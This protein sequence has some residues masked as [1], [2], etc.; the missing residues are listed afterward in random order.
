MGAPPA[1][2][3]STSVPRSGTTTGRRPAPSVS[4]T[5]TDAGQVGAERD[6]GAVAGRQRAGG[7]VEPGGAT[8]HDR[9]RPGRTR[10]GA[11]RAVRRHRPGAQ[12]AHLAGVGPVHPHRA[13]RGADRGAHRAADL[14]RRARLAQPLDRPCLRTDQVR[15]TDD[16]DPDRD[17]VARGA[18]R[19][20]DGE[21]GAGDGRHGVAGHDEPLPA[22]LQHHQRVARGRRH[23]DPGVDPARARV[24][25]ERRA[26]EPVVDPVPG[27]LEGHRRRAGAGG[28]QR[29]RDDGADCGDRDEE[30]DRVRSQKSR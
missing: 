18:L 2:S 7:R 8:G 14:H 22:V 5:S 17:L 12:G 3:A 13:V 23:V 1:G 15:T 16:L 25:V 26:L 21:R 6:R 28:D 4:P 30:G 24:D 10:C 27:L 19:G 29:G 9:E 11:G 20:T